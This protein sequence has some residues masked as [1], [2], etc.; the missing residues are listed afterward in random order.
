MYYSTNPVFYQGLSKRPKSGS[1][2]P[3]NFHLRESGR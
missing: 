3:W 2:R 1:R